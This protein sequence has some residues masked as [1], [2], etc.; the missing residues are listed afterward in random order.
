MAVQWETRIAWSSL[1]TYSASG[2]V[3]LELVDDIR[4]KYHVLFFGKEALVLGLSLI[5]AYFAHCAFWWKD[6]IIPPNN[7]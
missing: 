7:E 4:G 2:G 5:A 1:N 6:I 3:R